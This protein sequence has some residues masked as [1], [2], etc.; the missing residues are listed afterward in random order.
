MPLFQVFRE[1]KVFL[2]LINVEGGFRSIL[3]ILT[4]ILFLWEPFCYAIEIEESI[5]INKMPSVSKNCVRRNKGVLITYFRVS[6]LKRGFPVPLYVFFLSS[7]LSKS[8]YST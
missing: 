2:L 5:F 8:A 6:M 4:N 1:I 3:L 7:E